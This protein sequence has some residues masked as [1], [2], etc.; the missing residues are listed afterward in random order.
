MLSQIKAYTLTELVIV[1]TILGII[2]GFAM[3]N[4]N[5]AIERSQ[6]RDGDIQLKAIHVANQIYRAQNGN[7]WPTAGGSFD[8]TDINNNLGLNIISNGLTYACS[9]SDGGATYTCTA[10]RNGWTLGVTEQ[11]L[12][13]AAPL[14]PDCTAGTCP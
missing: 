7:Y 3:P 4:Y 6:R 8:L 10:T 11:P 14:N 13:D 12:S 1:I 5:K 2:A 9:S